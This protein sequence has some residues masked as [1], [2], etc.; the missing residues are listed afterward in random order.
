MDELKGLQ[1]TKVLAQNIEIKSLEAIRAEVSPK[2]DG[3]LDDAVWQLAPAATDFT[4]NSPNPGQP[5]GQRTEVKVVY[6]NNA[7]YIGATCYDVA[8]DSIIRQLSNRDEEDNTDVFGIFL[9]TYNDD[10]NAYGFVIHP[11]GV[12]WDARYSPNG[13]DVSWDAVW[14]SDV[15]ID[16]KNWYVEM[17][18][19]FSAIRFS[20]EEES[21]TP[22]EYVFPMTASTN[23]GD[24]ET[25]LK[26]PHLIPISADYETIEN[27]DEF[28]ALSASLIEIDEQVKAQNGRFLLVYVPSKEHVL[29]SRFWDPVDVNHILERTVTVT[30]S[31]GDNGRLQFDPQI[32][33]YEQ[34][35]ENHLAQEQ[36]MADFAV[37]NDIEFLNLT[38]VFWQKTIDE[39]EFFHFADTHWNQAGNQLA[40]DTI[41][42]YIRE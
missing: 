31:D 32:L 18:I 30:L 12:Q 10:Q 34:F 37:E 14:M 1:L 33:T 24:V 16:D 28:K 15:Y 7:I 39:G 38:P 36:L 5:A 22:K 40:A 9:D 11:T 27:S 8:N 17:K 35:N 42:D 26:F 6:D 19:P 21:E 20:D 13:Q 23:A 29:W 25:I 2:I 4:Q 41:W 3:K